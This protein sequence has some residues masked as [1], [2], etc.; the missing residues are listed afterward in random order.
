MGQTGKAAQMAELEHAPALV[1]EFLERGIAA[2]AGGEKASAPAG[3]DQEATGG[4]IGIAADHAAGNGRGEGVE[5]PKIPRLPVPEEEAV[6]LFGTGESIS[7][8]SGEGR[9]TGEG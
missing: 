6:V 1:P 3:E 7:E 5:S 9:Q 2:Q 8:A 4:G